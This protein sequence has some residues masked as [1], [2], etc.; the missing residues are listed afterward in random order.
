M[1]TAHFWNTERFRTI[2]ALSGLEHTFFRVNNSTKELVQAGRRATPTL[3]HAENAWQTD[4]VHGHLLS[5]SDSL[6]CCCTP[7]IHYYLQIASWSIRSDCDAS[8]SLVRAIFFLMIWACKWLSVAL[9]KLVNRLL[10]KAYVFSD[11]HTSFTC[12]AE[13]MWFRFFR[14]C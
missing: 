11:S 7:I 13:Q 12:G 1:A 5:F 8:P 9:C 14:Y 2:E 3:F 10:S 4:Y 6:S